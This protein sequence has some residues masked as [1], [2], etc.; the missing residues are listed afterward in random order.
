LYS[1]IS[2]VSS[3]GVPIGEYNSAVLD[4]TKMKRL[5]QKLGLTQEEAARR[6]GLPSRARWNDIE[7][8]RK[9]NV[10]M[11]SLDAIAKALAV[12]PAELLRR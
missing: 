12:H 10:T 2:T 8:G 9:I 7:S 4:T 1:H 3:G 5:R 6:A 11:E